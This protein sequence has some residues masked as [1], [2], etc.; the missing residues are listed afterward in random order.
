MSP[1][2]VRDPSSPRFAPTARRDPR[3]CRLWPSYGRA[4]LR[5]MRT[6]RPAVRSGSLGRPAR[7]VPGAL[8]FWS[9]YRRYVRAA[10]RCRKI[11]VPRL[12]CGAVRDEPCAAAGVHAGLAAGCGRVPS[13]SVLGRRRRAAGAGSARRRKGRGCRIRPPAA[14]SA[15]SGPAPRS[16]GWRSR[17]WRWSWA[18][19]RS[20]RPPGRA[21]SRWRR[22]APRSARPPGC[23]AGAVGAWRFA[24]AVTGGRLIAA[25]TSRP[26]LWS[27][28]GVSCLLPP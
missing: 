18:V 14:G 4:R 24:S 3:R 19:R 26:G 16:W 22:S 23:R 5:S 15:G 12:R 25:N 2:N 17:R 7:R 20:R 27:A 6:R 8:V 1:L 10:G 9:G 28:G 21:G 13:G 11:F